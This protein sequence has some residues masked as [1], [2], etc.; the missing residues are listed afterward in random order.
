MKQKTDNYR[1]RFAPSPSGP[2]HFGSLVAALGSW[3]DARHHGGEWLIRIEDIDPPREVVGSADLILYTLE[4]FGLYW[5]QKISYQHSNLHAYQQLLE[6][7]FNRNKVYRCTC[8]RKQIRGAGNRYNN[9]CRTLNHDMSIPHSIRLNVSDPVLGFTDCFQG[10]CETELAQASE[11]FILKRKDGLF[12]YMLAVV[13]DDI[14][15]NITHVIRGSDLLDTTT[16]QLYLFQLL[17]ATTPVYGHLPLAINN[18]G[19]KLSKQNHA[20][21][22]SVDHI[23][24]TLW[25]ALSFLKQN[26][27][28][29][30]RTDNKEVL[31]DWAIQHWNPLSFQGNQKIVY[32]DA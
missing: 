17:G 15:Q 6:Q 30:L 3:L 19:L 1:G 29:A 11:D 5:D 16:Q 12:A 32:Q 26:P 24:E 21:A 28:Q 22:I 25:Q 31:L 27:P 18:E 4:K 23:S 14:Q 8:T 10:P 9:R 20:P 2:L 7:L 13:A